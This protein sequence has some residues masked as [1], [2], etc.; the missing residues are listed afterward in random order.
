MSTYPFSFS[1]VYFY[2]YD[3]NINETKYA[4]ESGMGFCND[5]AEAATIISEY[6]GNDLISIKDLTLYEDSS[7][8]LLPAEVIHTYAT[9]MYHDKSMFFC[10]EFGDPIVEKTY[11]KNMSADLV[12]DVDP[13][14]TNP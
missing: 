11:K 8:I 1:A 10:N 7:V 3:P 12:N 14:P 4:C 9:D 6:Y 13:H 2:E 5:F